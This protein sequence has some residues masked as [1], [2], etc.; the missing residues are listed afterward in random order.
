MAAAPSFF[1][2]VVIARARLTTAETAYDGTGSNLVSPTW[3][4][5]AGTSTAPAT[6]WLL[7]RVEVV[8]SGNAADSVVNIFYTDSSDANPRLLRSIDIGDPAATSTTVG[9][10]SFSEVFGADYT[11]AAAQ[12]LRFAV[13]VTPT[14]GNVEVVAFCE[15]A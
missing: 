15:R 11:F 12:G 14:A 4:G 9:A 5:T 6:D 3:Y 10:T 13:T 8:C 2:K 7:K 1:D